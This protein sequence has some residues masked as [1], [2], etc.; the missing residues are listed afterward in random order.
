MSAGELR[1]ISSPVWRDADITG[2]KI[3]AARLAAGM[4]QAELSLELQVDPRTIGLWER[5]V[6]VP[7][8][9]HRARLVELLDLDLEPADE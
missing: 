9:A 3:K 4:T 8:P 2:A 7:Q 1:T 6:S 5:D